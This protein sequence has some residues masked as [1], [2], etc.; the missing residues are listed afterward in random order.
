MNK[1]A[2]EIKDKLQIVR[3]VRKSYEDRF[4]Y[5][6]L[7]SEK[8]LPE[9]L[10]VRFNELIQK[11]A[12]LGTLLLFVLNDKEFSH[13]GEAWNDEVKFLNDCGFLFSEIDSQ[14]SYEDFAENKFAF[15]KDEDGW[16]S[17]DCSE[18]EWQ[19]SGASCEF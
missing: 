15:E 16:H 12:L 17:S 11:E 1:L 5:D 6:I 18:E 3:D 14:S 4:G 8:T 13:F 2:K 7:S 10:R 19:S 9:E